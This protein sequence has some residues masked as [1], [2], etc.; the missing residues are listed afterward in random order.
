[1]SFAEG[2]NFAMAL[3]WLVFA[4]RARKDG[5]RLHFCAALIIANVWLAALV[6]A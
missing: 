1:M 2:M 5:D 6:T 4:A 3:M